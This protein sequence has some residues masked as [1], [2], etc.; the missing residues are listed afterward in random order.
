MDKPVLSRLSFAGTARPGELIEVRW[1]AS[2]VMET[3]FRVDDSGHP[4][5]RNIIHRVRVRVDGRL[6]LDAEPGTGMS[7]QPYLAFSLRVPPAGGMVT[8]EWEDDRGQHGQVQRAIP[9]AP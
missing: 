7:A 6:V 5:A 9:L 3:G 1:L 8:V 2:H 4:I